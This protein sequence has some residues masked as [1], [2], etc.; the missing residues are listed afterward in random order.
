[1]KGFA[2]KIVGAG[3]AR[4]ARAAVSMIFAVLKKEK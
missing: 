2:K 4:P 1:M 3:H